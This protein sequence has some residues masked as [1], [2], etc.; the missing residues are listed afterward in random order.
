MKDEINHTISD[1]SETQMMDGLTP[2]VVVDDEIS[3][4]INLQHK[5]Y[6]HC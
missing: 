6:L 4:I 5:I 3:F 1:S 2:K